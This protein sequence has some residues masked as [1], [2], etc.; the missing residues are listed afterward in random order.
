MFVGY[1]LLDDTLYSSVLVVNSSG[2]PI[3]ADALPTFRVYGPSGYLTSGTCSLKDTGTVANATNATPIVITSTA[4][5]LTTGAR[6][7]VSGVNGN[8][9]ANG[10]FIVT[11][12]DPNTFSLNSSV[13]NGSYTTGGTWNTTGLYSYEI[14][15][16]GSTGFES[17]E[18][19]HVLFVY[20]VS[21]TNMGQ[22]HGFN[23][24]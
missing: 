11:R 17:S 16:A 7:T 10:T 3:N 18:C 23:V 19:Y 13:G 1:V 6:I 9:A 2:T 22:L 15:C 24:D 4:H 12:V 8:T 14:D 21:S 5:G 20:Q